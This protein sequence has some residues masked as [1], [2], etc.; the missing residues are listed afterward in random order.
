MNWRTQD[1][2]PCRDKNN[3]QE[4]TLSDQLLDGLQGNIMCGLHVDI[5][6][7]IVMFKLVIKY[8]V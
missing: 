5:W 4:Q 8:Y 3:S 2:S 1:N 7:I 6:C